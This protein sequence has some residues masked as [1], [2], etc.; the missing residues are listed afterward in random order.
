MEFVGL[1]SAHN[2][3]VSTSSHGQP[4][5]THRSKIFVAPNG[6]PLHVRAVRASRVVTPRA[7]LVHVKV[8]GLP[9][10]V[11]IGVP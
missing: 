7:R 2:S 8:L 1:A 3:L 5:E 10:L 11:L 4:S 9:E 6:T